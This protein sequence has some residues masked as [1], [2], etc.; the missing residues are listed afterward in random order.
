MP[1]NSI[2]IVG[3]GNPGKKYEPTRHNAGF[4]VLDKFVENH[5]GCWNEEKKFKALT[6]TFTVGDKNVYCMKPLTFMN[7]SGESVRDFVKWQRVD[8]LIVVYDELD[9]EPGVVKLKT[10]GSSGGHNGV[11]DIIEKLNSMSSSLSGEGAFSKGMFHRIRIGIGHPRNSRV[12]MMDVK[13]WVLGKP[14]GEDKDKLLK[15]SS[16]VA[17]ALMIFI[18]ESNTENAERKFRSFIEKKKEK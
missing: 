17:E 5:G 10:S 2:L 14:E 18:E 12:P 15:A 16:V 4:W 9:F 8:R 7:L 6:Y 11:S 13:D 3:L 1:G